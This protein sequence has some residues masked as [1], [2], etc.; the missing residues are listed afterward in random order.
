MLAPALAGM[1]GNNLRTLVPC[2]SVPPIVTDM[3][4]VFMPAPCS[5]MLLLQSTEMDFFGMPLVLALPG[6]SVSSA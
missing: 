2:G 3:L 1:L 6:A 5:N 4:F